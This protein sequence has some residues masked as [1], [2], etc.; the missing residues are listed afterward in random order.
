[1]TDIR[2]EPRR[3]ANAAAECRPFPS[4]F[5]GTAVRMP[6]KLHCRG[7]DSRSRCRTANPVTQTAC[8]VAQLAEHAVS[9]PLAARTCRPFRADAD[10]ITFGNQQVQTLPALQNARNPVFL[11]ALLLRRNK[12]MPKELHSLIHWSQVRILPP[13]QQ[14]GSSAGRAMAKISSNPCCLRVPPHQTTPSEKHSGLAG[15]LFRPSEN[16]RNRTGSQQPNY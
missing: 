11:A 3:H 14:R 9:P 7:F 8:G 13:S 10:R 16:R 12:Q 15:L 1:M 4:T 6:E 5:Y 2:D